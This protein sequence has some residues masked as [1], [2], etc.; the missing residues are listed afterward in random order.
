MQNGFSAHIVIAKTKYYNYKNTLVLFSL[1]GLKYWPCGIFFL[2]IIFP[3]FRVYIAEKQEHW[4]YLAISCI[5]F[6]RLLSYAKF[7]FQ[8]DACHIVSAMKQMGLLRMRAAISL[9]AQTEQRRSFWWGHDT[10]GNKPFKL[11][12]KHHEADWTVC[13]CAQL[14][15]VL[16]RWNR[17]A[18]SGGDTTL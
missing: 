14:S 12:S 10:V 4:S 15:A 2:S 18:S 6:I 17:G 7:T 1:K 13:A 3:F 9:P 11:H 8:T 16:R 5:T